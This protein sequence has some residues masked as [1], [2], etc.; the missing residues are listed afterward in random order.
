MRAKILCLSNGHGEDAIAVRILRE[1]QQQPNPPEL[2]AL[3]LVGIGQAY[4]QLPDIPIIGSVQPMPSGGFIYMDHHQFW[5]DLQSGLLP[6]FF[7]QYKVIRRWVQQG[8]SI[9]AVGDIVPLLLA[10]LSGG[11]YAF[12][13]TAKSDY[14]LRDEKEFLPQTGMWRWYGGSKSIYFP[15]ERWLMSRPQCKAVFPRD[16]LTA[17]TLQGLSIRA[18]NLGN[19]MMDDLHPETTQPRFYKA[20]S[21]SEEKQ[22]CLMITLLPGSRM[23]EAVENW[24]LIVQAVACILEKF[25][26]PGSDFVVLPGNHI[27]TYQQFVFLAAIAPGLNLDSFC[28]VLTA[29][30]WQKT[31]ASSQFD[32]PFPI[33][34]GELIF[35]Q[36]NATLILTQQKFNQCLHQGHLAIAMA[37]TATEQFVGLGK[38]AIALPG[39][40]PQFTPIFAENQSR[41]LGLSL[42]IV[43]APTAVPETLRSLLKHPDRLQLIAEN[44]K[45]RLGEPGASRRI[46]ELILQQLTVDD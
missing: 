14:Y 18:F 2:A 13:G 5:Q 43:P 16:Q 3:P 15:W 25:G 34:E 33:N 1:L 32:L 26:E 8:G 9:L 42:I 6:L 31:S 17:E 28:Q 19:P 20:D 39:N 29:F 45:R 23:P 41:L 4:T 35:T 37:G 24:Q 38:P 22:Q 36:K 30:N 46:A 10:W 11:N 21:D 27:Q 12:V 44:G 40:G 7:S